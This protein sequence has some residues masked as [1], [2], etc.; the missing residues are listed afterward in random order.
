MKSLNVKVVDASGTV[1]VPSSPGTLRQFL[2][3]IVST[4]TDEQVESELRGL[5]GAL[6]GTPFTTAPDDDGSTMVWEPIVE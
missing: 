3:G 5:V 2:F 1:V 6:D 4:A